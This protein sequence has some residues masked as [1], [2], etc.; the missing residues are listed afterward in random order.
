MQNKKRLVLLIICLL[1]FSA[2]CFHV[3][4][5]KTSSEVLRHIDKSYSSLDEKHYAQSIAECQKGLSAARFIPAPGQ[6]R[7]LSGALYYHSAWAHFFLGQFDSAEKAFRKALSMW[8]GLPKYRQRCF[9]GLAL[10]YAQ[11]ERYEDAEIT[12]HELNTLVNQHGWKI[13]TGGFSPADMLNTLR[14]MIST[15]QTRD[16]NRQEAKEIIQQWETAT[17]FYRTRSPKEGLVKHN[18]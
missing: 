15:R 4:L 17:G 1:I 7:T 18:D 11:W 13:G 10:L 14:Q 5:F 16:E 8:D 9:Y 3:L 6:R 2:L 12:L